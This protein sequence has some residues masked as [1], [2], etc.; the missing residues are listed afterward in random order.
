MITRKHDANHDRENR[1]GY[2]IIGTLVFWDIQASVNKYLIGDSKP[3]IGL[4]ECCLTGRSTPSSGITSQ[5][6]FPDTDTEFYKCVFAG[7]RYYNA[8]S[9]LYP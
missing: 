2:R 4:V 6:Q 3:L 8:Q 5:I 9:N 1:G 7:N